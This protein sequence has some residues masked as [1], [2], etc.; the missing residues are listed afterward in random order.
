MYFYK[1]I[2]N[3]NNLFSI[4]RTRLHFFKII[5]KKQINLKNEETVKYLD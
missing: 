1:L 4:F 2:F 3:H 5:N